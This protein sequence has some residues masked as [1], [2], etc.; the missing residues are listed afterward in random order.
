MR[1]QILN[2]TVK[3]DIEIRPQSGTGVELTGL[4]LDKKRR[5][6]RSDAYVNA[7]SQ[8]D[9]AGAVLDRSKIDQIIQAVA[10]EFSELQPYQFPIGIISKCYLGEPYEV[11]SLD[12]RLEIIEHYKKG[13]ALPG[14]ME[15][16]RSLAVHP[17]YEFI[18]IYSDSICAVARN[19]NVSMI[20][21]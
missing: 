18:E 10:N 15:K 16:G 9:G 5:E 19:G 3:R 14:G 8:L 2:T 13:T 1:R 4:A 6:K 12:I 21:G 11:H 7:L 20:K 17:G